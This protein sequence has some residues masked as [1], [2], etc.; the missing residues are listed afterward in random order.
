MKLGAGAALSPIIADSV[1]AKQSKHNDLAQ[2]I[3]TYE[4]EHGSVTEINVVNR[5]DLRNGNKNN[6]NT[7]KRKKS[8]KGKK[9]T[10]TLELE[11]IFDDGYCEEV[12]MKQLASRKSMVK[13]GNEKVKYELSKEKL[14]D[15]ENKAKRLRKQD[16]RERKKWVVS[17]SP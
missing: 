13:F 4:E 14:S 12:R 9:K 15:F 16:S 5:D 6:R 2:I 7:K 11:Y 1:Q 8:G 17:Q 3:D 10:R